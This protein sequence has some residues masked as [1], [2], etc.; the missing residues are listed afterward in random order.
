MNFILDISFS[1]FSRVYDFWNLQGDFFASFTVRVFHVIF[2]TSSTYWGF[3][4]S[5]LIV[6]KPLTI[7]TPKGARYICF[8]FY[9]YISYLNFMEGRVLGYQNL[10]RKCLYLWFL[11]F[12]LMLILLTSVKFW[13]CKLDFI[14]SRVPQ[15]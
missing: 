14:S 7:E 2:I 3:S 4:A 15:R 1:A 10:I 9:F 13:F 6:S 12:F 5:V 11:H 8:D